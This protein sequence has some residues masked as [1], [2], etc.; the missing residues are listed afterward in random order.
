MIWTADHIVHHGRALANMG[1]SVAANGRIAAFAP[2]SALPP[3]DVNLRGQAIFPGRVNPYH[4]CLGTLERCMAQAHPEAASRRPG[5]AD[6]AADGWAAGLTPDDFYTVARSAFTR[7]LRC[8]VTCVGEV[9]ALRYQPDGT[10]YAA[11]QAM[12]DALLNAARDT[13]IRLSVI[14]SVR[15]R[16]PTP[17]TL[18]TIQRQSAPHFEAACDGF[19]ALVG[20]IIGRRDPRLSWAL[21]AHSLATV[22]YDALVGL[23]VR[24]GHMPF[25]LGEVAGNHRTGHRPPTSGSLSLIDLINRDLL[26]ACVTHA[27]TAALSDDEARALADV[28][29]AVCLCLATDGT[30]AQTPRAL[31]SS[32]HVPVPLLASGAADPAYLGQGFA[33]WP[34]PCAIDATARG[35]QWRT[36]AD[37]AGEMNMGAAKALGVDT[38]VFARG[39]WADFIAI[40]APFSTLLAG[41]EAG[42]GPTSP[43]DAADVAERLWRHLVVG[44]PENVVRH[45]VVGGIPSLRD[46]NHPLSA[47]SQVH[48]A[49]LAARLAAGN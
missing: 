20:H 48:L 31:W 25:F 4:H 16:Q 2:L 3:V 22:P 23:R 41:S 49:A 29:T 37:C 38:G 47:T 19:D 5:G 35:P 34:D 13:G 11:P 40:D 26:D 21:G 28:G 44:P 36:A 8:G 7:L 32:A 45:V 24:L 46:G 10:S 42:A 14:D 43:G 27:T 15:L 18:P 17:A 39:R 9:Y 6:A 30:L 33:D 1:L 12:L